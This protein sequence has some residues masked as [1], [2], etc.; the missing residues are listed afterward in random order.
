MRSSATR[1]RLA[2]ASPQSRSSCIIS[3]ST[4]SLASPLGAAAGEEGEIVFCTPLSHAH[5]APIARTLIRNNLI[6]MLLQQCLHMLLA[7]LTR[8]SSATAGES[9]LCN[10]AEYSS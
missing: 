7:G 9:E 4:S 5:K 8:L 1:S 3:F 2:T 10:E 6:V